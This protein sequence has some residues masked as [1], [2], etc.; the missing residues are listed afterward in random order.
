[1]VGIY[2]IYIE[3]LEYRINSEMSFDEETQEYIYKRSVHGSGTV[4]DERRASEL[5][6]DGEKDLNKLQLYFSLYEEAPY[7]LLAAQT[8]QTKRISDFPRQT[9]VSKILGTLSYDAGQLG[10]KSGLYGGLS[11]GL[12]QF[13]DLWEC[14][15]AGRQLRG[16]SIAV[17]GD[18]MVE[19][20]NIGIITY[21]W[22]QDHSKSSKLLI[23]GFSFSF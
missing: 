3:D 10:V 20:E 7:E 13:E 23:C 16:F 5:L 1:M 17:F 9:F 21:H 19:R 2:R 18:A 12:Q 8:R 15:K 14:A 4:M 22:R 11:V 6:I